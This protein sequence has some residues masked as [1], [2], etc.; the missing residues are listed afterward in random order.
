MD[1]RRKM[2]ATLTVIVALFILVIIVIGMILSS[3]RVISPVP[4]DNAIKI[5]FI[6][7]TVAP[8][9]V[10]EENPGSAITPTEAP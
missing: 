8:A 6:T 7:P 3:R 5:I 9:A 4:E 10:G 2:L 1:S